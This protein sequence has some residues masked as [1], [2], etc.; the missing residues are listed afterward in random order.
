MNVTMKCCTPQQQPADS[1][2]AKAFIS[3]LKLKG[4]MIIEE[5][6]NG[7]KILREAK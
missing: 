4:M 7:I 2:L 6:T 5:I 1:P 3:L